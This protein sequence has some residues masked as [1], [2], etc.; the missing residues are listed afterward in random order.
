M[1]APTVVGTPVSNRYG[2]LSVTVPGTANHLLA[3]AGYS[4]GGTPVTETITFGGVSMTAIVEAQ[5]GPHFSTQVMFGLADPTPSTANIV[6]GPS[7]T[8][9]RC[10][11]AFSGVDN[12]NAYGATNTNTGTSTSPTVTITVGADG[13]AV[14]FLR[15]GGT[16]TTI[17]PGTDETVRTSTLVDGGGIAILTKTGT[18]SVTFAPTLSESSGWE[19]AAVSLNGTAA[20]GPP[21]IRRSGFVRAA[22]R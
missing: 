22:R 16:G 12:A 8:A 17:T 5:Q 13:L 10:A 3:G 15:Y 2:D 11:I 6:A 7:G 1:P 21:T 4:H 9:N 20:G 19:L 18:G 14:A